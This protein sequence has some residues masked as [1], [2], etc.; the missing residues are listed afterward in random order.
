MEFYGEAMHQNLNGQS[1]SWDLCWRGV[2]NVSGN[3]GQ[4]FPPIR[5]KDN[6]HVY[7]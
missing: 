2:R 1:I 6:R 3:V 4:I 7:L 5:E